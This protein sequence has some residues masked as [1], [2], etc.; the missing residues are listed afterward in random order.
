FL[1][2][3][4]LAAISKTR[5]P[6]PQSIS[7]ISR[8]KRLNEHASIQAFSC[9]RSATNSIRV[10]SRLLGWSP[11]YGFAPWYMDGGPGQGCQRLFLGEAEG[12]TVESTGPVDDNTVVAFYSSSTCDLG[13]AIGEFNTGCVSIDDS[14]SAYKSF[15][16]IQSNTGF[17]R[18][19][20]R[21]ANTRSVYPPSAVDTTSLADLRE[22]SD[23][24]IAS[25]HPLA[26]QH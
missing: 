9:I 16:V 6:F 14:I 17:K 21:W 12:V 15:N 19:E 22:Q 10:Q 5:I 13:T 20:R 18:R 24:L 3:F 4:H 26:R 2:A 1:A 8:I 7:R 23:R 25:T 11:M